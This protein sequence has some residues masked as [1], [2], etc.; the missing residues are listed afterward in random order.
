MSDVHKCIYALLSFSSGSFLIVLPFSS[1]RGASPPIANSRPPP[2]ILCPSCPRFI[3]RR[4]RLG[5]GVRNSEGG[6]AALC[7]TL[8]DSTPTMD[9]S[10]SKKVGA[11]VL[12]EQL[13]ELRQ[14]SAVLMELQN[15]LDR[16]IET[17]KLHK[18]HVVVHSRE[19][20]KA[21][22]DSAA[23]TPPVNTAL[24]DN[25]ERTLTQ[26]ID[27][28]LPEEAYGQP[29]SSPYSHRKLPFE[30][31]NSYANNSAAFS[32]SVLHGE[33]RRQAP[34]NGV[35]DVLMTRNEYQQTLNTRELELEHA[36][37]RMA[38]QEVEIY[39]LKQ[40]CASL[41]RGSAIDH[42]SADQSGALL[43][44]S[45]PKH[46]AHG[47]GSAYSPPVPSSAVPRGS[48]GDTF[49][50]PQGSYHNEEDSRIL[51]RWGFAEKQKPAS[52]SS[53][54]SSP[55][56]SA[57]KQSRDGE[58]RPSS[59]GLTPATLSFSSKA[60][61]AF[62]VASRSPMKYAGAGLAGGSGTSP[63]HARERFLESELIKRTRELSAM[64]ETLGELSVEKSGIPARGPDSELRIG[65]ETLREKLLESEVQ[66]KDEVISAMSQTLDELMLRANSK[67]QAQRS[68][69]ER[70][71]EI[72]MRKK[73]DD[74][75]ALQSTLQQVLSMTASGRVKGARQTA[76]QPE[77]I[78]SITSALN[79]AMH[80]PTSTSSPEVSDRYKSTPRDQ[81]VDFAWPELGGENE[82][83][84]QPGPL[85]F[86]PE[87]GD[88]FAEIRL[89]TQKLQN[90]Q[91]VLQQSLL[92]STSKS[93]RVTTPTGARKKVKPKP[94]MY[95]V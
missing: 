86:A 32:G 35:D 17:L 6:G 39:R 60:K 15:R 47:G 33:K 68:E 89:A 88:P 44:L 75:Q 30:A 83:I 43:G 71:L 80:A 62:D 19:H 66:K 20:G 2:Q 29:Q 13:K 55:T 16:S 58:H 38:R 36:T 94:R 73:E 78:R 70:E 4:P 49:A 42:S 7:S 82:R 12:K 25:Q 51:H 87:P 84:A 69:R 31:G 48:L 57:R 72:E 45:T 27:N 64:N 95:Y 1:T 54:F 14:E 91:S 92:T 23:T 46:A 74:L 34:S 67:T 81:D 65:R 9:G 77:A 10:A 56:L 59:A 50:P 79:Q 85:G 40:K 22:F 93:G 21:P 41:E 18:K 90:A 28:L 26:F 53:K 63:L 24:Y 61:A 5:G 8:V 52:F 76:S 11:V 3:T 37:N